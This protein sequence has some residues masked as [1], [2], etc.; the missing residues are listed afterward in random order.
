M[1]KQTK[2]FLK[3]LE[4]AERLGVLASTLRRW[5][6]KNIIKAVRSYPRAHRRFPLYEVEKILSF[7]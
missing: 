2:Q 7:N 4:A 3:I 1:K 6:N 5:S